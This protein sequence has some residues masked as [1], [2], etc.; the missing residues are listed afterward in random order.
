MQMAFIMLNSIMDNMT[1]SQLHEELAICTDKVKTLCIKK[2]IIKKQNEFAK[3]AQKQE[4]IPETVV[5]DL[6]DE[7]FG[8][9]SVGPEQGSDTE[10]EVSDDETEENKT[11]SRFLSDLEVANLNKRKK[12]KQFIPP[13]E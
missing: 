8:S 2:L 11:K 6:I 12:E 9:V 4:T 10:R 5:D 13:Y 1:I 7:L 3:F